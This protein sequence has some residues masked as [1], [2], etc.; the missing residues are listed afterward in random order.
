[1]DL[2]DGTSDRLQSE[3]SGSAKSDQY[4]T[5]DDA[6]NLLALFLDFAGS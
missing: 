2:I 1:M 4:Y 5:N 3:H 6:L